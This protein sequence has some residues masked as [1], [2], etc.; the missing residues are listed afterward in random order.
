M[1]KMTMPVR[2]DRATCRRDL[3]TFLSG[4]GPYLSL[5]L[6]VRAGS[7]RR[8]AGPRMQA[9]LDRMVR[10]DGARLT[11][12][13]RAAAGD[14]LGL[15]EADDATLVSFIHPSGEALT[16]GYDTRPDPELIALTDQPLVAPLLLAEQRLVHH[17]AATVDDDRLSLKTSPRHGPPSEIE[18][19]IDA[20]ASIPA[21]I[22]RTAVLSR[23]AMVA[24]CGSSQ[25]LADLT[26]A[27]R[28]ALP[29]EVRLTAVETDGLADDAIEA[30]IAERLAAETDRKTTELVSLWRFHRAHGEA[31]E[32]KEDVAA[33]MAE[34]R[35]GLLLISAE[36][37]TPASPVS[38][39][40][41]AQQMIWSLL[42]D[43][44][45]V[46]LLPAANGED[47]RHGVGAILA[48]RADPAQ[49]AELL[50]R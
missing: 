11:S 24:L 49:L 35:V 20:A 2:R 1:L 18:L 30:A 50:E 38:E 15:V 43:D 21:L 39:M 5:Y 26:L 17:V 10:A 23:T 41:E 33:A 31:V 42:A 40:L 16:T 19:E 46:H 37:A 13:Q 12:Q 27:V 22:Q 34:G 8:G 48:D 6:D 36:L 29:V 4:P 47:V 28:A 14:L 25:R 45:P 44:R 7:A 9:Q 3:T 32:G